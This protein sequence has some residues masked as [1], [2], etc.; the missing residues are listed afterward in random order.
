MVRRS[1]HCR[2][3]DSGTRRTKGADVT[4]LDIIT[5]KAIIQVSTG[6]GKIGPSIANA[7]KAILGTPLAGRKVIGV[8]SEGSTFR[9]LKRP[10]TD[11]R[12]VT[13]DIDELIAYLRSL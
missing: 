5:T 11:P 7:E 12:F 1:S 9:L 3:A 6:K 2:A 10:Q 8:V 13:N 4:D